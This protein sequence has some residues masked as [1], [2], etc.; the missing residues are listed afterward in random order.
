MEKLLVNHWVHYRLGFGFIVPIGKTRRNAACHVVT[1]GF[2][3][4]PATLNT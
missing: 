4:L 1:V 3:L 2:L